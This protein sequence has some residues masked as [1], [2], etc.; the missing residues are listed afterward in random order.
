MGEIIQLMQG[1]SMVTLSLSSEETA[2]AISGQRRS[3]LSSLDGGEACKPQG[4][5]TETL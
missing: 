1:E 3:K 4:A 5:E 2:T